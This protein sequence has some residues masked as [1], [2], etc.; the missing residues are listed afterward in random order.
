MESKQ[1]GLIKWYLKYFY[2]FIEW[3]KFTY[4]PRNSLTHD[5]LQLMAWLQYMIPLDFGPIK[6]FCVLFIDLM[7][8]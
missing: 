5:E 2:I 8:L 4:I 3:D 1:N 7:M 6:W